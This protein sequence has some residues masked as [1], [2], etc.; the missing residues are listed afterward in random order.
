KRHSSK[1]FPEVSNLLRPKEGV[2]GSIPSGGTSVG[3]LPATTPKNARHGPAV[4][5]DFGGVSMQEVPFPRPFSA[6][7][8][9]R[10]D[11]LLVKD[12]GGRAAATLDKYRYAIGSLERF[13][14]EVE[15]ATIDATLLRRWL[16][17]LRAGGLS[18]RT[19]ADYLSWV[20]SWLRWL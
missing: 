10:E 13:A 6:F 9:A 2:G 11:F 5:P 17:H 16:L 19:Q 20:K 8:A 12:Q 14:G 3:V 15:P 7:A 1:N 18:A 4:P